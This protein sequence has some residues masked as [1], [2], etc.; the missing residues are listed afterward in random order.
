MHVDMGLNAAFSKNYGLYYV[1]IFATNTQFVLRFPEIEVGGLMLGD[2]TLALAG[3][4]YVLEKSTNTY[5]EYSVGK[6]K[7]KIYECP[8]KL[9]PCDLIG[10]I[11]R[12]TQ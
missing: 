12:V 10:G 7:K 2:R 1:H 5:V 4:G 11:F 9:K 8:G 6:A 3:K